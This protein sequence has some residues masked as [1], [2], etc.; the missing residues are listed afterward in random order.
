MARLLLAGWYGAQASSC[1]QKPGLRPVASLGQADT[2]VQDVDMLDRL[3]LVKDVASSTAA[4]CV[5]G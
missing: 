3:C 4:A 5:M 2:C 1:W